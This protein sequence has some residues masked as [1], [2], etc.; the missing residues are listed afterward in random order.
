LRAESKN[1]ISEC[2]DHGFFG[3]KGG[4]SRGLYS[5]LNCSKFVGDDESLVQ[6]NLDN[7]RSHLRATKLVTLN[8]VHGNLCVIA[9]E[10]T[11]SDIKADALV[12]NVPDIAI[13]VLTADCV[14]ILFLDKK[15]KIAGAAHAGWKGAVGGI[16]EATVQKMKELGSDVKDICAGIGPCVAKESYEVDE[17]FKANFHG[18]GDCFCIINLKLHFDL[19]KYCYLRLVDQGVGKDNIEILGIDTFADR[20]SYFS[21]RYANKNTDGVCGRQISAIC[22]KGNYGDNP[23]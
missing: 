13:G 11:A 21:F 12:T 6:K 20:E 4:E 10:N 22:L 3:R 17:E 16:V 18:R 19:P 15:N 7:V 5:S 8:Q 9:D 2:C 14:P 23:Y 1:L